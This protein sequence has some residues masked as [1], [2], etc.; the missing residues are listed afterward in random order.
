[1]CVQYDRAS[2]VS[3]VYSPVNAEGG[4]LG[5]IVWR[6]LINGDDVRGT[7]AGPVD[8]KRIQQKPVIIEC[9]T[10]VVTYALMH[11]VSNSQAQRGSEILAQVALVSGQVMVSLSHGM[12]V[13]IGRYRYDT[14]IGPIACAV[15]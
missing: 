15:I 9:D 10:E 7:D 1:M 14:C 4:Y 6:V 3:F 12:P 8:A 11:I 13:I 2:R 5:F